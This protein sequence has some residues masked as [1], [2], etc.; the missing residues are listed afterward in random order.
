MVEQSLFIKKKERLIIMV[1]LSPFN[2]VLE[3]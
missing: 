2:A 3:Y 1:S